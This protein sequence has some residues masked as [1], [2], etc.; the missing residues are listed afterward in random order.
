MWAG[1]CTAEDRAK[2]WVKLDKAKAAK[3]QAS[4]ANLT[5]AEGEAALEAAVRGI[6]QGGDIRPQMVLR[7]L[8][9]PR[10]SKQGRPTWTL[11]PDG[12]IT[13]E[14][15][16]AIMCDVFGD[17]MIAKYGARLRE[18]YNPKTALSVIDRT[19]AIAK[20][21]DA[22]MQLEHADE[23]MYLEMRKAGLPAVRRQNAR[24]EAV[25]EL[26]PNRDAQPVASPE[27]GKTRGSLAI[28]QAGDRED[29]DFG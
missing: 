12:K 10:G 23:A 5:L 26:T 14:R 29:F 24:I 27:V 16:L 9:G 22:V 21:D 19:R 3:K 2:L 8:P 11:N 28:A 4:G 1:G 20:L 17:E 6:A 15:V 7:Q 25:L 18:N 13:P